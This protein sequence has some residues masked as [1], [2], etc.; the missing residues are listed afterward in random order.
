M[1]RKIGDMFDDQEQVDNIDEMDYDAFINYRLL[2][3]DSLCILNLLLQ[4]NRVSY[5]ISVKISVSKFI[6]VLLHNTS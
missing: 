5:I 4:A 3:N 6:F 1:F 2:K